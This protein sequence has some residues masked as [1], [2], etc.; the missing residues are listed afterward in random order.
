MQ[1]QQATER[2]FAGNGLRIRWRICD[3]T[4][5]DFQIDTKTMPAD[6]STLP[7]FQIAASAQGVLLDQEIDQLIADNASLLTQGRLGAGQSDPNIRRSQTVFL[8]RTDYG[9]LYQKIWQAAAE[10]NRLFFCVD[11]SDVEGN[12]QLARYDSSNQG[13]YDWHTDF[14]DVAPRRKI[15]ISIQLSHSDDYEGGDLELRYRG[16]PDIADR[17]KGTVIAFPSFVLHRVTPVIG[18]TRWSLVAWITGSRWR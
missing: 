4:S 5:S 7:P 12:V 2:H 10:L 3:N 16:K 11:I 6:E 9:W 15:S 1:R 13:F 17:T 8:P 14:G 18:G